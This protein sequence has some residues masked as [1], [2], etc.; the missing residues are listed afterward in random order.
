MPPPPNPGA[1]GLHEPT[2]RRP[3]TTGDFHPPS[4]DAEV[5]NRPPRRQTVLV[6][7]I[8]ECVNEDQHDE[9]LQIMKK[10][11]LNMTGIIHADHQLQRSLDERYMHES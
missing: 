3:H 2:H 10:I 7:D 11:G 8:S 4:R 1:R 9:A 6:E 5:G